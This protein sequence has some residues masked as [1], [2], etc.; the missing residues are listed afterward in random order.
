MP[1]RE[2]NQRSA[3]YGL[4]IAVDAGHGTPDSGARGPTGLK[5]KEVVLDISWCLVD[6]R[7]AEGAMPIMIGTGDAIVPLYERPRIAWQQR[8]DILVSIHALGYAGNPRYA[9]IP[10]CYARQ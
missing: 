4:R 7:E 1:P 9:S 8:A 6:L 3:L 10:S 2:N 5:E